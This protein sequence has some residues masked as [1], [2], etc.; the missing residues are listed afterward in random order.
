MEKIHTGSKQGN[1]YYENATLQS[2]NLYESYIL[3]GVLMKFSP[4]V[5]SSLR[6]SIVSYFEFV[7]K[8]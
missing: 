5:M 3:H 2:L 1:V 8:K 6:L 7:N 4:C